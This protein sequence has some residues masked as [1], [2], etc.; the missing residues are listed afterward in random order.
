MKRVVFGTY[1]LPRDLLLLVA[2][3]PSY[4]SEAGKAHRALANFPRSVEALDASYSKCVA[5]GV[6]PP[7]EVHFHRQMFVLVTVLVQFLDG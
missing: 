4:R 7:A 2:A 1:L 3:R 6:S 5:G